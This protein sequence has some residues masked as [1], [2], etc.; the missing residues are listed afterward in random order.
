MPQP[1][2]VL[3]TG[4]PAGVAVAVSRW[5]TSYQGMSGYRDLISAAAPA[6]SAA[7]KLVPAPVVV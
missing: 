6:V 4:R 2:P 1:Y 7:A 5:S 3:G